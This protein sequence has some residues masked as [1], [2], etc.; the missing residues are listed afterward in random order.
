[1]SSPAFFVDGQT[2]QRALHKLCP[3]NPI[4]L[5]GCN[6]KTVSMNAIAKRLVTH[7]KLLNNRYYPIII[8]IDREDRKEN[9]KEIKD[10]L[11]DEL[12][13]LGTKDN[14]LLG[15]CDRMIENWILADKSNFLNYIERKTKLPH[16]NY[17]GLKGK[18]MIKKVFPEYHETTDGV[19]LLASS[20]P[21][22]MYKNSASFK[23][24]AETIKP[25][26]CDWLANIIDN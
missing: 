2:E 21:S 9:I 20:S 3:G 12:I 23:D 15:V 18:S 11:T 14:I 17:E 6:G 5:I 22:E 16:E 25:L 4:R 10:E 19:D 7:I 13:N 26:N 24:F 8:L 1:M